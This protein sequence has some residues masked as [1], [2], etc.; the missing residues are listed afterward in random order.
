[1]KDIFKLNIVYFILIGIYLL[2]C[3]FTNEITINNDFLGIMF[4]VIVIGNI[5]GVIDLFMTSTKKEV[6]K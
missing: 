6:K 5:I 4:V 3:K 1:M 2:I